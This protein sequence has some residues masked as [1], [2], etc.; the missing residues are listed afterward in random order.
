VRF[1][2]QFFAR[3]IYRCAGIFILL[4]AAACSTQQAQAPPPK[5]PPLEF[6]GEWGT[7]GDGPGEF[8]NPAGI[9]TDSIGNVY[10]ADASSKFINKFSPDGHPL[11]SFQEPLLKSPSGIAV[12]S[13]DAIYVCDRGRNFVQIFA[14]SG[15]RFRAI[16]G[17]GGRHFHQPVAIAVDELGNQFVLDEGGNRIFKFDGRGRFEKS[18][19]KAGSA[20]GEF[21]AAADLAIGKDGF[22]Y[23]A[24]TGNHRVQKFSSG[25]EF[26]TAWSIPLPSPDFLGQR[27][28]TAIAVSAKYVFLANSLRRTVDVWTLDGAHVL[29]T[30]FEG[31][32]SPG[33]PEISG[34]ALSPL[35][36]L[37]VLDPVGVRV[38]RFRIKF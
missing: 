9:A 18:W 31:R 14:P 11:L 21:Q 26:I 33:P 10:V 36:E 29:E 13:G 22:L 23:V 1:P 37:L 28:V 5:P 2:A 16:T 15:D 12:D 35:G 3:S 27:A 20:S 7:K 34:L 8:S 17:G 4:T 6:L 32:L 25:G 30:N 24:D 38:L 19:G